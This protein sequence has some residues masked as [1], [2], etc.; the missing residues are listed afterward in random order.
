MPA[1]ST[2]RNTNR[3]RCRLTDCNKFAQTRGLCKAHGG[4]SRCRH[5]DCPKLAQSRGLCI[6]HGGGRRCIVEDCNKLA[7]SKGHCISHGGGRR[8]A[9]PHCDKFSQV[10]GYCKAHAKV[11]MVFR[12]PSSPTHAALLTPPVSA[13]CS[14]N[15]T[16]SPVN[17]KLSI[18][19]L[20][21]PSLPNEQPCTTKTRVPAFQATPPAPQ[22]PSI[23]ASGRSLLSF[24]EPTSRT[25]ALPPASR[26]KLPSLTV[27]PLVPYYR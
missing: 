15:T 6:A 24:L 26:L 11:L 25:A 27:R 14:P 7:Q 17:S 12:S 20:V 9:I 3:T 16:L 5:P 18:D 8:C 1:P 21:N 10:R 19:F 4:G 23:A 13:R 22:L 2:R